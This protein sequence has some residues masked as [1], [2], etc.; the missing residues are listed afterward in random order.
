MGYGEELP[1][2]VA[3]I[4]A[5]LLD[6]KYWDVIQM[7]AVE[8]HGYVK[9]N[10]LTDEDNQVDYEPAELPVN[11]PVGTVVSADVGFVNDTDAPYTCQ[12]LVEFIDPDGMSRGL[13]SGSEVLDAHYAQ[14]RRTLDIVLD[15]Q[16]NWQVHAVMEA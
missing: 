10:E 12:W 4:G 2:G 7:A 11:L 6:E 5:T 14:H 16:G 1:G 8:P 3:T 9:L 13:N 15:K